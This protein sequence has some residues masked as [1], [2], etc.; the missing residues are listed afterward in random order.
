ML[1]VFCFLDEDVCSAAWTSGQ[2]VQLENGSAV[3]IW[4]SDVSIWNVP[5]SVDLSEISQIGDGDCVQIHLRK[6]TSQWRTKDCATKACV[7]CQLDI[8]A[9]LQTEN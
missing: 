2:L 9:E 6:F 1:T 7:I 5:T 8:P 4:K 3:I